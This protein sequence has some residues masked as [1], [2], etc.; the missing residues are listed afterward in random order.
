M[1]ALAGVDDRSEGDVVGEGVS[2]G[3]AVCV[4]GQQGGEVGGDR[5]VDQ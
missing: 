4:F 5:L 2:D 3:E 1:I